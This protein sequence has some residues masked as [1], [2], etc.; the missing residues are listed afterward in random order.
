MWL[1]STKSPLSILTPWL[2]HK[3]RARWRCWHHGWAG[4]V[5]LEDQ[6]SSHVVYHHCRLLGRG[7]SQQILPRPGSGW[8]YV[9]PPRVTFGWKGQTKENSGKLPPPHTPSVVQRAHYL[10]SYMLL[11]NR[12][13][14]VQSLPTSSRLRLGS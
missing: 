3:P 1:L 8:G 11:N 4:M 13:L 2:D 9:S 6:G 12:Q 14:L 10:V 7:P 5:L